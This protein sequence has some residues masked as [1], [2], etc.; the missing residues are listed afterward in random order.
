VLLFLERGEVDDLLGDAPL[1]HAAIGRLDE[2]EVVDPRVRGEG[3]D[4]ADVGAFRGLDGAHPAVV[5]RMH[6]AHLEPGTLAREAAGAE[7]GQP[8][9]VRDLRQRIRLVHELREL[10]GPEEL[11]D[12]RGHRFVVDE[13]LRHQRLDVLQAHALLDGALH[14]HQ[15]DAVLVLDELAHGAHPAV[16]EVVDVV[17][18]TVAVLELDQVLHDLEDVL[19]AERALVERCVQL[20]LVVELE[21]PDPRQIVPLGIE[22]EVVEEGRRGLR[23]GWIS[24]TEPA[25]DL[26]DRLLRVRDLVLE[27]RVPQRGAD[28]RVVEEEH[29][30]AVDAA[31]PQ[32]LE[33]LLGDL[34]V[35]GEQH[36]AR[37][38]VL[39]VVCR[40]APEDFL[41]RD[42]DL[43]DP[44]MLHLAEHHLRELAPL[45]DEELVRAGVAYVARRLDA[46]QVIGLKQLGRLAA[47]EHDRVLPVEVVE[48][49]L[50]G[51]LQRTEDHRGMELPPPVDADEENVLRVELEVDPR[52]AVGNDAR[53][54]EQL[55]AGV[56]LALV[57]VEEHAGRPVQL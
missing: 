42:G 38:R 37:L 32:Q 49:V 57:V 10:R 12:D 27:Q 50:G 41:H 54:V 11:L 46:H 40:D 3:G 29:L 26:E 39:H 16:A 4:Q 43:L 45:L 1:L 47:V 22:E 53:G 55:A 8:A 7:G 31:L 6:V 48:N 44:C 17:D 35:A 52:A 24:R 13:L 21:A 18:L 34:L 25:V 30:D 9:L 2:A 20:E 14:P 19:P 23:R 15:A 28:V 5:G 36:L 33:L 56:S 51:H